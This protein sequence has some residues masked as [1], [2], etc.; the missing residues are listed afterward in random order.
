MRVKEL[1]DFIMGGC[2][3]FRS[4]N[5]NIGK[6]VAY[7]LTK[8]YLL[9]YMNDDIYCH[10]LSSFHSG[11][12]AAFLST[13]FDVIKTRVM[14][15]D[16]KSFY[17]IYI[18]IIKNEG[19]LSLWKGFVPIWVRHTPWQIAFWVSYEQLRLANNLDGFK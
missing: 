3:M 8:N 4:I 9:D 16:K 1:G 12:W 7:D 5:N 10:I 13:P 14:S 6:L 18:E 17:S 2:Q 15:G 11:F 19:I